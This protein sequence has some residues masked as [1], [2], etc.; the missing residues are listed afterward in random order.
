MGTSS[1][2]GRP[3][4]AGSCLCGD[5]GQHEL[6]ER[7][8]GRSVVRLLP[9]VPQH[10]SVDPVQFRESPGDAGIATA[11]LTLPES[12]AKGSSRVLATQQRLLRQMESSATLDD[13]DASQPFARERQRIEHAVAESKFAFPQMVAFVSHQSDGNN[14][15]LSWRAGQVRASV[16][17]GQLRAHLAADGPRWC[18]D[19]AVIGFLVAARLCAGGVPGVRGQAWADATG[20]LLHSTWFAVLHA[21][22]TLTPADRVS[23]EQWRSEI[24]AA[25]VSQQIE[26]ML[27]SHRVRITHRRMVR[28]GAR[29][30]PTCGGSTI[31]ES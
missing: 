26:C 5:E 15:G 6:P 1:R 7:R 9:G 25:M 4:C 28:I 22:F 17:L 11:A 31:R 29:R 12:A 8:C 30:C 3:V 10:Q 24:G 2:W 27:G 23:E 20:A 16:L 19:S 14:S 21:T 18:G 13:S